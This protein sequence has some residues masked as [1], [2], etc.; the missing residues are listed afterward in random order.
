MIKNLKIAVLSGGVGSRLWPL[1]RKSC[2]KQ[3]L[4]IFNKKSLFQLALERN[5]G[6]SDNFVIIGNKSNF[7]LSE[8]ILNETQNITYSQIIEAIPKNTAAAIAFAAFSCLKEDYL[9]VT[10]SDHVIE[11]VEGYTLAVEQAIHLASQDYLVTFG[12]SPVKP[13]TGYGY[14]ESKG[15]NVISFREK[16]DKDTAERFLK[17]GNFYWNSGMFCFKASVMLEELKKFEPEIYTAS[18]TAW[19]NA[20]N[21]ELLLEDM[22]KIPSKSI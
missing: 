12:V 8:N 6:I 11:D 19:N 10:P 5:S 20:Q 14:I 18:L 4:N 16:P 9:L 2:P 3:Y 7:H 21:G 13:D 17:A 15:N 22:Q 1:S